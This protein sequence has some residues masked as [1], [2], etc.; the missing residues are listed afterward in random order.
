MV[1]FP[2]WR[3]V[4]LVLNVP[5]YYLQDPTFKPF[6]TLWI[7]K[8]KT[9]SSDTIGQVRFYWVLLASR[10]ATQ[11]EQSEV[12]HPYS[13]QYKINRC[14]SARYYLLWKY[15]L[16]VLL[17]LCILS[18]SAPVPRKVPLWKI[19]PNETC[20][21]QAPSPRG[22]EMPGIFLRIHHWHPWV[23][24]PLPVGYHYIREKPSCRGPKSS[25]RELHIEQVENSMAVQGT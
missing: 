1:T 18:L 24:V 21:I 11:G 7:M 3:L 4:F 16:F 5:M 17:I 8:K 13:V 22:C 12:E 9:Y 15:P 10:L 2:K 6:I 14:H 20:I 25:R 23:S 19:G